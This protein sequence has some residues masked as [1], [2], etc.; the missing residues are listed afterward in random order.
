MS[1][2][3]T[4]SITL[5]RLQ[6]AWQGVDIGQVK[7]TR[8]ALAAVIDEYN[9]NHDGIL[10]ADE[11]K[12]MQVANP[13][14]FSVVQGDGTYTLAVNGKTWSVTSESTAAPA[15]A[16]VVG[17]TFAPLTD[18]DLNVKYLGDSVGI[19][20]E[21]GLADLKT[22]LDITI[23][24]MDG[25]AKIEERMKIWNDFLT[26]GLSLDKNKFKFNHNS[27]KAFMERLSKEHKH[28]YFSAMIFLN[29]LRAST[30]AFSIGFSQYA[31]SNKFFVVIKRD[32]PFVDAAV[33]GFRH[34]AAMKKDESYSL[35]WKRLSE[36]KKDEK[37]P[38]TDDENTMF[39]VLKSAYDKLAGK[40]A[41]EPEE[42]YLLRKDKEFEA[43][44]A[45]EVIKRL[46]G[47]LKLNRPLVSREEDLL[48]AMKGLNSRV[49][50]NEGSR[51]MFEQQITRMLS[52]GQ[53]DENVVR[54][55]PPRAPVVNP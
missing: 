40:P 20:T 48:N 44:I 31:V 4:D 29:N 30:E 2:Q 18:L 24:R 26:I 1:V 15:P 33:S 7:H 42:K 49:N 55:G 41:D 28:E 12:A 8:N 46:N 14:A 51:L 5:Q 6:N 32:A 37:T 3:G 50:R 45:V 25:A 23:K 13:A 11:I 36:K 38:L 9:K 16:P 39:D 21:K 54:K 19:T 34:F 47:R 27:F 35:L 17:V 10:D 52:I 43:W 22:K 53:F